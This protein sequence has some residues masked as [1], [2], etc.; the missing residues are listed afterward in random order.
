MTVCVGAKT[1]SVRDGYDP[2]EE[3]RVQPRQVTEGS[4]SKSVS[5]PLQVVRLPM[6]LPSMF[7]KLGQ[8][9]HEMMGL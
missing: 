2:M 8:F 4:K 7:T 5:V 3:R 9:V 6:V 1:G